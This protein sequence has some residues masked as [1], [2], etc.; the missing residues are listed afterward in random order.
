M[1]GWRTC[2]K[3]SVVR[4]VWSEVR[5]VAVAVVCVLVVRVF[6]FP[7]FLIPSSSMA[8]TLLV[9][10]RVAVSRIA[11]LSGGVRRSDVDLDSA[12]RRRRIRCPWKCVAGT[13]P[14]VSAM[15]CLGA[16]CPASPSWRTRCGGRHCRP[17]HGI[18]RGCVAQPF[19]R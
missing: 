15:A 2:G 19:C 9:G 16:C 6:V 10:D 7:V 17:C 4:R 3:E 8:G 1:V 5:V 11:M 12:D 13:A 18:G 14:D